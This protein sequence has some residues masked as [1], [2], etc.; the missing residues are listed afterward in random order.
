MKIFKH[1]DIEKLDDKLSWFSNTLITLRP[2]DVVM[3][4]AV[5]DVII[6]SIESSTGTFEYTLTSSNTGWRFE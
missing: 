3:A 2:G 4:N 5:E 1:S 6:S